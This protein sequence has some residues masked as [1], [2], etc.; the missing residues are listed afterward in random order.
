MLEIA[1]TYDPATRE[2][3]IPVN[4]YAG[5]TIDNISASI[6]I[7]GLP[8]GYDARLDFAVDVIDSNGNH[9][10]P[11]LVLD[12][13]GT[14]I[15]PESILSKASRDKRLPFQLVLRQGDEVIA[16]KNAVTLE[17]S[18]SINAL[19]TIEDVYTPYIMFRDSSWA[20]IDDVTYSE[21][22]VV[23]YE[24]HIYVSLV[25]GNLGNIPTDETKWKRTNVN[26]DWDATS[27]DAEIYN[28]PYI[29]AR[30]DGI[31]P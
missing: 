25:D 27:G 20:W 12:E 1:I 19:G 15:L 28:K 29:I 26:A 13:T 5:T 3:S 9:I 6:T 2:L 18:R 8:T 7:S 17:V 24:G 11:F 10:R 22:T 14:C 21:G 4:Q 16:S 30:N 23:T 31:V